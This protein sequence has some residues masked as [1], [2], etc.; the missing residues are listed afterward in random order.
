MVRYYTRMDSPETIVEWL[1]AIARADAAAWARDGWATAAAAVEG[2]AAEFLDWARAH[3][4][5]SFIVAEASTEV[6]AKP[7]E[8]AAWVLHQ[9][10]EERLSE[11]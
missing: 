8:A 11:S 2:C 9:I 3:R 10:V 7:P 6:C 5:W 4:R 1:T